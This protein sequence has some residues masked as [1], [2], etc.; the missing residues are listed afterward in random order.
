M[1][2]FVASSVIWIKYFMYLKKTRFKNGKLKLSPNDNKNVS[3][4]DN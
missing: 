2:S 1:F 4:S 3:L